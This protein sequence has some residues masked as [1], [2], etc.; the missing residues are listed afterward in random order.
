MSCPDSVTVVMTE[1]FLPCCVILPVYQMVLNGFMII[2]LTIWIYVFMMSIPITI[3][4][5]LSTDCY[6]TI[7]GKTL[8]VRDIKKLWNTIPGIPE[9]HYYLGIYKSVFYHNISEY[10]SSVLSMFN[11]NITSMRTSIIESASDGTVTPDVSLAAFIVKLMLS[12][13]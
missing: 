4:R 9:S 11:A 1:S 12:S 6:V 10:T 5:R 8:P 7:N 13:S 2:F 3:V